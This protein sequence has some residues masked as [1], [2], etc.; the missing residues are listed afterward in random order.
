VRA[1]LNGPDPVVLIGTLWPDRYT[2]YTAVPG[3]GGADPRAREREVLDLAA[4]VRIGPAFSPAE[5]GRARAAAA[6]DRRL[7]VAV[8]AAGYG[9]TQTLAAAPQLPPRRRTA[10]RP[11]NVTSRFWPIS[12]KS[13][14]TI[15]GWLS[16]AASTSPTAPPPIAPKLSAISPQVTRSL[17]APHV[18]QDTLAPR[19]YFSTLTST[20]GRIHVSGRSPL[21]A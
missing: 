9:L 16:G 15:I 20:D 3:P 13:S 14:A 1:L 6:R 17:P 11:S 4:V 8:E 18:T 10:R 5:Q 12:L 7:A 19:R 21:L 2:A